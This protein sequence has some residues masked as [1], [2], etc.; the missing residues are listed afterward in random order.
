VLD[1][2]NAIS[3]QRT[4]G[5]DVMENEVFTRQQ[6]TE[7]A[8]FLRAH[9]EHHPAIGLILGSG[10]NALADEMG[11]AGTGAADRIPFADIPGFAAPTVQGH[12]G[13]LVFGNLAGREVVI[14]Q[15]RIHPYEGHS[16]QRVTLPVRVMAGLGVRTLIV[17]NAAGGVNANFKA[18]DLMLITD[19]IGFM[20]LVGGN[21][22]WG[23]NDETL[24]PRFP[25]MNNAYDREL[26]RLALQ[27]AGELGIELRQGVY[28]GLGGPTFETPAEVRFL[29]MA[30]ADATGMS[31]VHEVIVARHMGLRVLG[32][33]GISNATIAD[34]DVEEQ[35]NHE[36][37]LAAGRAMTPKL[38]ALIRGVLQRLGD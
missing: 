18:G 29:R 32:F 23:P 36:E 16:M 27:V 9:T 33:S 8:D 31:T 4:G 26:R 24:G 22:L 30:G 35:A 20:A 21:P 12:Q 5:R 11:T 38:M 2:L 10:L 19:H 28:A 14:M 3:S 17:T 1:P 25:A 13:Q 6:Y 34:P 15:G 7:I 37:V